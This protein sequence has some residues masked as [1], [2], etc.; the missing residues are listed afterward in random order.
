MILNALEGRALPVY[1]DG[2]NVRDWLFVEDHAA[3]LIAI[4]ER[5]Q[6]GESYNVGGDSERTNLQVVER[7]CDLVDEL[8]PDDAIGPRRGLITFVTDRPGHDQRYAIDASKI[9]A[10]LGWTPKES[11][12]TGIASTVRWYLGNAA[13]WGRIRSGL[14][15][16][17]RLG[18]TA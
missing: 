15:R 14:Y 6:P 12:E 11:F 18:S 4:A 17:E 1:G 8:A 3:A 13:W 10:E 9:R 5:G 7:I 16:G 2:S